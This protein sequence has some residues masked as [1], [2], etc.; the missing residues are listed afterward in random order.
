MTTITTALILSNV[1]LI[2]V[3]IRLYIK[4]KGISSD[5]KKADI[6]RELTDKTNTHRASIFETQI[7]SI[8]D[9]S[10]KINL[11]RYCVTTPPLTDITNDFKDLSVG[12]EFAKVLRE[13]IY[14]DSFL[15]TV[16]TENLKYSFLRQFSEV[17]R[18]PIL[19][20]FKL[21]ENNDTMTFGMLEHIANKVTT[22]DEV[23]TIILLSKLKN[24]FNK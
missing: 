7:S 13:L 24:K 15:I 14:S 22:N 18:I 4:Y 20:F 21:K 11:C 6:L 9:T 5:T 12:F 23:I 17:H 2:F 8:T 1:V 19:R 3:C 16:E 10:A